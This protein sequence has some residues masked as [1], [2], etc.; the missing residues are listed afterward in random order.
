MYSEVMS[1]R[2]PCMHLPEYQKAIYQNT[3]FRFFCAL[4]Q[5]VS[6]YAIHVGDTNK[7]KKLNLELLIITIN[8]KFSH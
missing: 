2:S 5:E 8:N 7:L 4:S 3:I 6:V 1:K